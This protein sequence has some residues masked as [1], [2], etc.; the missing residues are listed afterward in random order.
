MPDGPGAGAAGGTIY[1]DHAATTPLR[2]E[3]AAAIDEASAE[4]FAN[5]SSP[6]AAGR[7]ARRILEDARERILAALGGRAAGAVRDRLV[8]TSGA[9]EA[10][11][12][13]VLGLA[14]PAA[15]TVFVSARDHASLGRA[16]AALA[17]RGWRLVE[18]P[19][20]P[21]GTLAGGTPPDATPGDILT[22]TLG[23]GQTGIRENDATVSGWLAA[24]PNLLLHADATQAAGLEPLDFA[25]S[26]LATLALAPHKFGGPRGIGGLVVRGGIDLVPQA[27][28]PQEGGLRGGTEAVP[29]AAGFARALELAVVERAAEAVRLQALRDR[30][31]AGLEQIATAVGL[32]CTV[33]GRGVR[34]LPHI[35]TFAFPGTERQTVVMAADLEGVCLATGTACASG[36]SDPA[37]ALEAMGLP[38]AISRAA[39]RASFGRGTGAADVEQALARLARVLERLAR[40]ARP[41]PRAG[42]SG[43]GDDAGPLHS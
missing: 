23:C 33:V 35:S 19:L 32:R 38:A 20:S 31:E 13:A 28:G 39:C 21:A 9:S 10:N 3:V 30:F 40:Q 36:S 27:P 2:P 41:V 15:G 11:R 37:P 1:L 8:F 18:R 42:R 26:G 34:R 5:P 7:A 4:G 17:A 25:G 22:L 6:H 29:L 43:D 14:A 24:A 12:L 16:A